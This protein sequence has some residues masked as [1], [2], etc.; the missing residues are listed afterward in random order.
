VRLTIA[1]DGGSEVT[2]ID[3][4]PGIIMKPGEGVA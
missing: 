3:G 2:K 4:K 1:I